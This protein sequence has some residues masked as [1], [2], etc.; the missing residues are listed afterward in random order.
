MSKLRTVIASAVVL[1]G[2][3]AAAPAAMG[4]VQITSPSRNIDCIVD[5]TSGGSASCLVQKTAWKHYPARP[6][7]CDL[8]WVKSQ[9]TLWK[10]NV[11]LGGCRGDIGPQC[12]T[13]QVTPCRV[14]GYGRSVVVGGIRCTST[15]S[16]MVCRRTTG[17]KRQGFKVSKQGYTLYR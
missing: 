16:G 6:R 14:L 8:D 17:A 13:G 11:T 2:I 7:S 1:A 9:V 3:A 4:F 10:R 12:V 5:A 15:T